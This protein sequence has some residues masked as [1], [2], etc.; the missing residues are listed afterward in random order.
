MWLA[1]QRLNTLKTVQC[2][3]FNAAVPGAVAG[4]LLN[5]AELLVSRMQNHP[6]VT[7]LAEMK[8]TGPLFF[9]VEG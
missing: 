9:I 6:E 3:R 8:S 7:W 4:D 2:A 1:L 5:Q